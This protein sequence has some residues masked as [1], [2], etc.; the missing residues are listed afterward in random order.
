MEE[1][2][3][4]IKSRRHRCITCGESVSY[5][6]DMNAIQRTKGDNPRVI[7]ESVEIQANDIENELGKSG[8]LINKK[9]TQFLVIMNF[10]RRKSSIRHQNAD[11]RFDTKMKVRVGGE[12][13]EE[14]ESLKTLGVRFDQNLN[15][16]NH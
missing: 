9:K 1:F 13:V 12:E 4:E 11:R 2:K 7:E 15:F 16:K 8:L 5:A 6:D 10:Q 3:Q 14:S